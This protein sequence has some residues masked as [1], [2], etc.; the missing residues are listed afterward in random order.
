MD[1]TWELPADGYLELVADI[2]YHDFFRAAA[3]FADNSVI[4]AWNDHHHSVS[5]QFIQ[6]LLHSV[7]TY[8]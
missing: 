7:A 2:I 8:N 6:Q 4:P 1:G 3:K 5:E